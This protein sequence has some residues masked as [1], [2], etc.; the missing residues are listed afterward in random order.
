MISAYKIALGVALVAIISCGSEAHLTAICTSTSSSTPGRIDFY[1]GTYHARIRAPRGT[2]HLLNTGGTKATG[3][4]KEAF[5]VTN[6]KDH[7]FGTPKQ[8]ADNLRKVVGSKM[9]KN[10]QITC[11]T[12][13]GVPASKAP[14][15]GGGTWIIPAGSNTASKAWTCAPGAWATA[16]SWARVVVPKATSGDWKLTTS[17][18]DQN[19]DPGSKGLCTMSHRSPKWIQGMAVADGSPPCK[20]SPPV[21][22]SIDKNSVKNCPRFSGA[23]CSTAKCNTAQLKSPKM[24]GEI[25]CV[26][27][28]WRVNKPG[29]EAKCT[30]KPV[31]VIAKCENVATK[32]LQT[33]TTSVHDQQKT[34][35]GFTDGCSCSKMGQGAVS[36]AKTNHHNSVVRHKAATIAHTKAAGASV[37]IPSQII[38]HIKA[39]KCGWAFSSKAYKQA[40]K[41]HD[42]MLSHRGKRHREMLAYKKAYEKAVSAAA[43]AKRKCQCTARHKYR[44]A[45]AAANQHNKQTAY[46]WAKSQHL[47]CVHRGAIKLHGNGNTLGKCTHKACPVVKKKKLCA[48]VEALSEKDCMKGVHFAED[49]EAAALAETELLQTDTVQ[50]APAGFHTMPN[51]EI[52]S[53]DAM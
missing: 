53:D 30:G 50:R 12:A 8:V 2:V 38:S 48:A 20:G 13:S 33:I 24:H 9:P 5:H 40:K 10:S 47:L 32:G 17:N 27:G 22:S 25:A 16:Q 39:G 23:V 28:K 18:T 21:P 44:M 3:N 35:D 1:F 36:T 42:A 4:F 6:S 11:Y 14:P 51:G 45:W 41:H 19:F 52:M 49:E 43:K 31:R 7:K 29:K 34:L 15:K 37:A 26:K 46:A